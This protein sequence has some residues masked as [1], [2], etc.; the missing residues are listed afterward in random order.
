MDNLSVF[1]PQIVHTLK[2]ENTRVE[3]HRVDEHRIAIS[4][5]NI[6]LIEGVNRNT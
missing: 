4:D 3:E 1:C 6:G 5:G 2:K